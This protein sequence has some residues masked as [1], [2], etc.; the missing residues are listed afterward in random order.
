MITSKKNIRY[1]LIEHRKS[2]E[3]K[4]SIYFNLLHNIVLSCNWLLTSTKYIQDIYNC[5][6]KFV[7]YITLICRIHIKQL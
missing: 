3:G 1:S 2:L 5:A 6:C 7:I 4:S